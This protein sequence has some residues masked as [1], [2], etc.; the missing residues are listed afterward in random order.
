MNTAITV[1]P[2]GGKA[3]IRAFL[4]VPFAIYRNDPNWVAPLYFERFEQ[5]DAKKKPNCTAGAKDCHYQIGKANFQ[6]ELEMALTDIAGKLSECVFELPTGEDV[7]TEYVNV[8]L[9][10]NGMT[11]AG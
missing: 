8:N 3:G 4:Y 1:R 2:V 9:E 11:I 7:D 6:Q 10:S 5:P